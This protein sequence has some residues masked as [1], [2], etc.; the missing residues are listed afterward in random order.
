M[1]LKQGNQVKPCYGLKQIS[2][3]AVKLIKNSQNQKVKDIGD[4]H[5]FDLCDNSTKYSYENCAGF[6]LLTL[7]NEFDKKNLRMRNKLK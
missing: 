1:L 2:W 7:A 4:G 3:A 6:M 5:V